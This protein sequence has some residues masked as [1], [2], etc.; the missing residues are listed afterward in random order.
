MKC[1]DRELADFGWS[2]DWARA[3]ADFAEQGLEPA[4]VV[5]ELRRKFYAVQTAD[6]EIF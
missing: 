2:A 3:F 1:W 6:G 5:C 4:R